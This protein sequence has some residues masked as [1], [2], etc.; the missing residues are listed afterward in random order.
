MVDFLE[1]SFSF[2]L[3]TRVREVK[4]TVVFFR[5][6]FFFFFFNRVSDEFETDEDG[7]SRWVY[8]STLWRLNQNN[9]GKKRRADEYPSLHHRS[10]RRGEVCRYSRNIQSFWFLWLD[11]IAIIVSWD[12]IEIYSRTD[13]IC[14]IETT[15]CLLT[16]W[17][18]VSNWC[19]PLKKECKILFSLLTQQ[20]FRQWYIGLW[21]RLWEIAEIFKFGFRFH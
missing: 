3:F 19:E 15:I 18:F 6:F 13:L 10:D 16:F 21:F 14:K 12:W 8:F 5:I 11:L 4:N 1:F 20:A 2:F 17:Y 7:P 9:G